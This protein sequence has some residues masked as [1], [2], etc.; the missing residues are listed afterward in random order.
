MVAE[1]LKRENKQR[2]NETG[3][4][5]SKS[6]SAARVRRHVPAPASSPPES[7]R[8]APCQSSTNQTIATHQ[9]AVHCAP[10]DSPGRRKL[11]T[12]DRYGAMTPN[13]SR[14]GTVQ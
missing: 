5:D 6:V 3:G 12:N 13:Q 8:T 9:T 10:L 11:E 1:K 4:G 14:T 2:C 7:A